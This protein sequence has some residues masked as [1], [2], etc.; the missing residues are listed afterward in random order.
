[1][2]KDMAIAHLLANFSYIDGEITDSEIDKIKEIIQ[3]M[4]LQ[5]NVD[6]LIADVLTNINGSEIKEYAESLAF[7]NMNLSQDEKIKILKYAVEIIEADGKIMDKEIFKLQFVAVN[8]NI[9]V[10][11]IFSTY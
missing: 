10:N 7:L 2:T 11:K 1:M 3:K 9:D 5:V 8:W 4:G 6:K